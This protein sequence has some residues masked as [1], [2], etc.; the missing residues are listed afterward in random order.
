MHCYYHYIACGVICTQ[1]TFNAQCTW[2]P[3]T[4][5]YRLRALKLHRQIR[6]ETR[7]RCATGLTSFLLWPHPAP[8]K[9]YQD[10]LEVYVA[11]HYMQKT[12]KT[13]A[14]KHFVCILRDFKRL[15]RWLLRWWRLSMNGWDQLWL[16]IHNPNIFNTLYLTR[17]SVT[18][19][20]HL[21]RLD[22][23]S[24]TYN[25]THLK[26]TSC[27]VRVDFFV[28]WFCGS[29]HID[30]NCYPINNDKHSPNELLR[31]EAL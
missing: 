19:S 17:E 9:P 22:M 29:W 14:I 8:L 18:V 10:G 11:A 27:I 21:S 13:M 16:M 7:S 3:F 23:F 1:H 28:Y 25:A 2:A 31:T 26:G 24:F 15:M 5:L 20:G 12:A 4:C 6:V 30:K